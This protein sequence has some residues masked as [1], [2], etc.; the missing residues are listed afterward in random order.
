MEK[1]KANFGSGTVKLSRFSPGQLEA[2][3]E[4]L[5]SKALEI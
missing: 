5:E 1:P 2:D 3:H 4:M